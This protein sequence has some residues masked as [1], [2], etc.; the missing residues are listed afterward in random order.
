MTNGYQASFWGDGNVLELVMVAG[1]T[2][3]II[4]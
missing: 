3:K 4:S 2:I 1:N